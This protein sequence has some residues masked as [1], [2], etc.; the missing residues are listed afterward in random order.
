[1]A[2]LGI[3]LGE[4]LRIMQSKNRAT[5]DSSFEPANFDSHFKFTFVFAFISDFCFHFRFFAFISDF[6]ISFFEG[7]DFSVTLSNDCNVYFDP[8][9][10]LISSLDLWFY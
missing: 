3:A 6:D 9:V 7:R 2:I 5:S 4:K 10:N 8:A 1:M